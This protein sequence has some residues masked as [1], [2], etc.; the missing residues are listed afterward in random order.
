MYRVNIV[1]FAIVAALAVGNISKISTELG[2][3]G[4]VEDGVQIRIEIP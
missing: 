4:V 1:F 2:Y 3:T